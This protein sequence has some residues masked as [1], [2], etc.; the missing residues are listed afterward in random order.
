M[1]TVWHS[2]TSALSS[3]PFVTFLLG[4][5]AAIFLQRLTAYWSRIRSIDETKLKIYMSWMPNI[6][7]WYVEALSSPPVID[8]KSFQKK[9]QEIIGTLQIM[10]PAEA[11]LAF[12]LFSG[13]TEMALNGDPK[14]NP[15]DFEESFSHLNYILCCEIHREKLKTPLTALIEAMAAP[16]SK[17]QV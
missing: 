8:K 15:K 14:F 2:I 6:A 11:M 10:G 7:D 1:S 3:Q 16:R 12:T 5:L 17:K 9:S 13:L 4:I